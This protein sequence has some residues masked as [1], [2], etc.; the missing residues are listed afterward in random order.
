MRERIR[1]KIV[2]SLATPIPAFTRRDLY[3]PNIAGKA[4][5]VI[6]MRRSEKT[7]LLW[8][9]LHDRLVSGT[10]REGLLYFNFEDERLAG[11]TTA[12]LGMTAAQPDT[13][14][15]SWLTSRMASKSSFRYALIWLAPAHGTAM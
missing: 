14:W 9:I 6:G 2:D 7:T 12:D 3:V 4:T 11:M 1:Q 8:Q 15:T 10:P 13:K 5:A